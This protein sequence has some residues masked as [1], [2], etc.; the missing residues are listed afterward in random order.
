MKYM[1]INKEVLSIPP[2]IS[3]RWDQI[4]LLSVQKDILLVTLK[5][6][7]VIEVPGLG[8]A[9]IELIF[10][11]H[12]S[13]L[14]SAPNEALLA[15]N[16][17]SIPPKTLELM[18]PHMEHN[19][20]MASTADMP[21]EVMEK[22][23]S[24]ANQLFQTFGEKIASISLPEAEPHCNCMHC[25]VAKAMKN[26]LNKL[27]ETNQPALSFIAPDDLLESTAPSE[28]VEEDDLVFR[29]WNVKEEGEMIFRVFDE[30]TNESYLV[31]LGSPNGCTCGKSNCEHLQIVKNR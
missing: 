16:L 28:K 11:Q 21:E 9:T 14:E 26:A 20:E 4:S 5:S 22:I 10:N 18:L 31:Y 12:S 23:L 29:S 6:G 30:A 13:F 7:S 2:Y 19:P 25:Q 8:Q 3:A 24:F 27:Q 1:K 17:F 15:E